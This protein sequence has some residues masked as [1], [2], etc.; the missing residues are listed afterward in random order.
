M[1]RHRSKGP[2]TEASERGA[3]KL[4]VREDRLNTPSVL[5]KDGG[6]AIREARLRARAEFPQR[7]SLHV[8]PFRRA[9]GPVR[10]DADSRALPPFQCRRALKLL[11][12]PDSRPRQNPIGKENEEFRR[13][14][15]VPLAKKRPEERLSNWRRSPGRNRCQHT[16]RAARRRLPLGSEHWAS[17]GDVRKDGRSAVNA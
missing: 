8:F 12:P 4:N 2:K 5:I 11:P 10:S 6:A 16:A 15:T 3:M 17:A 13:F 14:R 7:F 9:V 1:P